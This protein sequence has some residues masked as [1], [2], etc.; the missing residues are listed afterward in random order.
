MS[1]GKHGYR[2]KFEYLM[3]IPVLLSGACFAD[4][5]DECNRFFDRGEYSNAFAYCSDACNLN[6]GGGCFN[7]GVLYGIR[8]DYGQV[9][10]YFEKACNLNDGLGCSSLG[11]L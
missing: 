1:F 7:L 11:V 6:V 3:L 2:M 9:R 4:A 8:Q 5:I 10:A